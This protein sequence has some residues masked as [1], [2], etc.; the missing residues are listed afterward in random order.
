MCVRHQKNGTIDHDCCEVVQHFSK[1]HPGQKRKYEIELEDQ[2]D[3]MEDVSMMSSYK[4]F[5]V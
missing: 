4:Q 1:P 2:L 3:H 5:D